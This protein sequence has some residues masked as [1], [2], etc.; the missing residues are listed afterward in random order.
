MQHFRIAIFY[1]CTEITI[2][3]RQKDFNGIMAE[4]KIIRKYGQSKKNVY[5]CT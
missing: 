4:E 1:L 5:L 2:Y 3:E